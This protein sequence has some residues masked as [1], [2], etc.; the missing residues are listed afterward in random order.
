M[1]FFLWFIGYFEV[2]YLIYKYLWISWYNFCCWL[3][4]YLFVI[5]LFPL[6]TFNMSFHCLLAS[7][8]FNKELL[9]IVFMSL[10]TWWVILFGAFKLVFSFQQFVPDLDV[11]LYL[12]VDLFIFILFRV[13]RSSRIYRLFL[14]KFGDVLAIIFQISLC[15]FSHFSPEI[16]SRYI[17]VGMLDGVLQLFKFCSIFSSSSSSSFS[18]F[19]S[20]EWIISFDL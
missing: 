11:D 15:P 16:T 13:H 10:C 2:H 8:G 18:F 14:I 7:I 1:N 5:G 3:L 17:Y 20:S 4:I 9:L 19:C 6:S 12:D